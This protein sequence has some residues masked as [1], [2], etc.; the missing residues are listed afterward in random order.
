MQVRS[1]DVISWQFLEHKIL[2]LK[3]PLKRRYTITI[4]RRLSL[5]FL[6]LWDPN[7]TIFD[8]FDTGIDRVDHLPVVVG[9][10]QNPPNETISVE[11]T[12]EVWHGIL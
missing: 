4:D 9:I 12:S 8:W 2:S 1:S 6:V 3:V 10:Y 11:F 5:L 7:S